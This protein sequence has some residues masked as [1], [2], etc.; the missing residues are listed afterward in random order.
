MPSR[1]ALVLYWVQQH[2]TI[3]FFLYSCI[4]FLTC[5]IVGWLVSVVL[6]AET[7]ALDGLTIYD[8]KR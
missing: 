6:Q 3:N 4:G 5:F 7:K 2:T 8:R 1:C